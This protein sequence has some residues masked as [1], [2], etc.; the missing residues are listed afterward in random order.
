[1][2]LFDNL[3]SLKNL[4]NLKLNFDSSDLTNKEL[5]ELCDQ[6]AVLPDLLNLAINMSDM[7]INF[8]EG[9]FKIAKAVESV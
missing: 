7:G 9:I 6:I 8:D 4:T 1:M 3:S 2:R 5:F